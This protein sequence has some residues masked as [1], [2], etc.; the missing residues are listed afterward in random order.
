MNKLATPVWSNARL[1]YRYWLMSA[2]RESL[3]TPVREACQRGWSHP[4]NL[5]IY[6]R[7]AWKIATKNRVIP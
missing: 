7:H 1:D 2:S 6:R 5:A 4:V 3:L